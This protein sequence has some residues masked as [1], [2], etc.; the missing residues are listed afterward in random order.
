[1]A[2]GQQMLENYLQGV[3]SSTTISGGDHATDIESLQPALSKIVLTPVN[4]P[5][6]HQ[7]L[8]T[9]A[10]LVFPIDIVQT[11][12]A[13]VNFVLSNPFT[14][15]IN[16]LKMDAVAMYESFT[17][18]EIKNVDRTSDPIHADGHSNI[19]SP[20]LPFNFNLNPVDIINLLLAL[21]KEK[22]IDFGPLPELFQLVLSNPDQKTNASVIPIEFFYFG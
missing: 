14:A 18:G 6:L 21:S 17:L 15:A 5:P 16:L 13:N 4:I 9:S 11:G 19:T 7:N 12:I 2:N 22:N 3:Q 8:I 20:T 10:T 1:M